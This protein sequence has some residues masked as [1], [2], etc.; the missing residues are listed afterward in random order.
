MFCSFNEQT[1]FWV[2][3]LP[4]WK[5]IRN[6][7]EMLRIS[8]ISDLTSI[9][10]FNLLCYWI[11][12]FFDNTTTIDSLLHESMFIYKSNFIKSFHIFAVEFWERFVEF[13]SSFD[14]NIFGIQRKQIGLAIVFIVFF[15]VLVIK[16]KWISVLMTLI[17]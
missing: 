9:I 14:E 8:F 3:T 1:V 7:Q 2:E 17:L 15:V 4:S 6:N 11:N 12:K 13:I 16:L 10:L 5:F